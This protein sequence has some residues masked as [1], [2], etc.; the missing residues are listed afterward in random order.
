MKTAQSKAYLQIHIAVLLFGLTAILGKYVVFDEIGVVWHRMWIGSL[1]LLIVPSTLR[2][3]VKIPAKRLLTFVGIGFVVCAHWLAFFGS[4]KL[5][6]ASVALACMA[7][8]TFF[9]SIVEP[10]ITKSK[11]Q[12]REMLLGLFAIFGILLILNIG[13][14][15]YKSI[16]VG[17]LAAFLAAVFSSLNKRYLESYNSVS[18]SF[19]ELTSGFVLLTVYLLAVGGVER[20]ESY[21][22]FQENVHSEYAFLGMQLHSVYFLLVLGLLCTSLAYVLALAALRGISAFSAGLAVN[23]EPIYGILMAIVLF[24]EHR[25]LT[26]GFYVGTAIILASVFAEPFMR[27]KK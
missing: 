17:L 3:L 13:E 20:L 21:S 18:V 12:W 7:T 4:I 14:A 5:G 2:K 11:F 23:L 16:Q 27:K 22:L 26:P 1:G 9:I 25:E 24:Q 10:L 8:S 6:N 15:Y 19:L